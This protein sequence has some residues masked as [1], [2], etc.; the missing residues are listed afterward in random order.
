MFLVGRIA[1]VCVLATSLWPQNAGPA[2]SVGKGNPPTPS[3]ATVAADSTKLEP[4][5]TVKAIY[6]PEAKAKGIEGTAVVKISVDETGSVDKTEVVSGDPVLAESCA[7]ALKQWKF[8]P[9]IKNGK[10]V[11]VAASLPCNFV[12]PSDTPPLVLVEDLSDRPKARNEEKSTSAT[13]ASLPDSVDLVLVKKVKATYPGRAEDDG[14]QGEVAVKLLVGEGGDVIKTEL[15]SG[16]SILAEAAEE[17]LKKWKFE[18]F[19]RSGKAIQVATVVTY[20]FAFKDKV[21]VDKLNDLSATSGKTEAPVPDLPE[22]VRASAGVVQGLLLYKVAPVYPF[23]A[24]AMGIQGT[25][26]LAAIIGKDGKIKQLKVVSGPTQLVDAA[27]G[28]VQQW[29][30][31]PYL[32][33]GRPVE[34]DTTI[35]VN[36]VLGGRP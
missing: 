8:K 31:R 28:A 16:N 17:A 36:F 24:K 15:V 33:M 14:I 6:P 20:D 22:S 9:Y 29:R 35:T 27:I 13:S 34:V 12:P 1:T 7:D 2:S 19:I 11:R 30:Y 4:I 23:K 5:Q 3:S 18:P 10:P 25:V 32:L 21:I 26:L